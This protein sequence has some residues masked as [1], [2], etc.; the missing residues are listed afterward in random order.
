MYFVGA[1]IAGEQILLVGCELY[2]M[3]M[4]HFL[5]NRVGSGAVEPHNSRSFVKCTVFFI[6]KTDMLPPL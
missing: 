4:G 2:A 1:K 3:Q 6:G 5:A